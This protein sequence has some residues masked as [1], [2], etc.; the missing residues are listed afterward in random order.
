VRVTDGLDGRGSTFIV[1]FPMT[2]D[3]EAPATHVASHN[4]FLSN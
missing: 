4:I 2:G 3:P 1:Q